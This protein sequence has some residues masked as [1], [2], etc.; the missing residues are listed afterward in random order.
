M[1]VVQ[2]TNQCSGVASVLSSLST[3]PSFKPQGLCYWRMG[4][5]MGGESYS[6]QRDGKFMVVAGA[7]AGAEPWNNVSHFLLF[8]Y[9]GS[10]SPD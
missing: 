5:I 7:V 10:K 1:R 6:N 4:Q 8:G 9:V 3:S 2:I